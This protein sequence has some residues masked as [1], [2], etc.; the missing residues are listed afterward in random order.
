MLNQYLTDTTFHCTVER[1]DNYSKHPTPTRLR[2]QHLRGRPKPSVVGASRSKY[3]D[4]RYIACSRDGPSE[5][6]SGSAHAL[7]DGAGL[8]GRAG[9]R[10]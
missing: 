9:E 7:P 10:L 3:C 2:K 6:L 4:G 1:C 8:E 5:A